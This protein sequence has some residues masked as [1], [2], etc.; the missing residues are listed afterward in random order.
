MKILLVYP[1]N[2]DTFWSFK[3]IMK[4]VGRKAAFPPLGLLTVAAM[5]PEHWQK[6]LV[7][8]N[9]SELTDEAIDWADMVFISAMI[10]QK[11]SALDVIQRSKTR[12]K[13][14]VAGGPLFSSQD[15]PCENVDHFVLNE[16][17]ATLP[18][19]LEDLK[20]GRLQRVYTSQDRPDIK[21]TPIPMWSLINLKK[22]VTMPVQYSRG[23]PYDCEFCDIVIMNGRIPRTKTSAQTIT[24]IQSLYDAGWRGAVFIVDDNFIGNSSKVKTMLPELIAWQK[25]MKYPFTFLTEASTDLAQD[26]DLL[27]MMS[28]ANFYKVF[29]G[30]ETPNIDSLKE[31][32]KYQNTKIDLRTAV[33][34]IHQHGIQVMGGFIVGFDNDTTYV[35]DNQLK[36]IQ[37][38]GV[39]TAMVGILTAL[40]R[41]R[42]WR[43]LKSEGRLLGES[44][45][46][47]MEDTTNF[48][49]KMGIEKLQEGYR[50]LVSTIYTP[51]FYYRR[52]DTFIKSYK[53]RVHAKLRFQDIRAFVR[54]IWRIGLFSKARFHYWK[55]LIKTTL[56][57]IR[58]LPIATE[59][60]IMGLHFEKVSRASASAHS[61]K[62][63]S[64]PDR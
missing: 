27:E 55:L 53:P 44:S 26:E 41:T 38:V 46:G 23:C 20:A 51:K 6:K 37:Q 58:C 5:L 57:R 34:T 43:R 62:N 3:H 19:F 35:F 32:G 15:E 60:A 17:E 4:F 30:L 47:N 1:Q 24:E 16:A 40:P 8:M 54:S 28:A 25:R 14:V 11:E 13:T 56:T 45:G 64:N 10:V 33:Q 9:V 48:I 39:V 52:I 7:D 42:L 2:P 36:F 22:Y 21:Q 50:N 29:V 63:G 61:N 18:V 59:L 12:G 31:C 49:P